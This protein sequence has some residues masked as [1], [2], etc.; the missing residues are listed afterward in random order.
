MQRKLFII[1]IFMR[2]SSIRAHSKK[3]KAKKIKIK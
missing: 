2:Y 1:V 3:L